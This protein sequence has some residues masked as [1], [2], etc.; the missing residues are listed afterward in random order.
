MSLLCR[1]L[2]ALCVVSLVYFFYLS[3]Y[4]CLAVAGFAFV[5]CGGFCANHFFLSLVCFFCANFSLLLMSVFI[6]FSAVECCLLRFV[7]FCFKSV[8]FVLFI[9]FCVSWRFVL[10]NMSFFAVDYAF[11]VFFWRFF[12]RFESCLSF[13]RIACCGFSCL[14]AFFSFSSLS[15]TKLTGGLARAGA[16]RRRWKSGLWAFGVFLAVEFC[17]RRTMVFFFCRVAAFLMERKRNCAGTVWRCLWGCALFACFF[18][19]CAPAFYFGFGNFCLELT[20][21]GYFFMMFL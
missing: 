18:V 8:L 20:K 16:A 14:D 10:L 9:E 13:F 17:G 2:R 1:C 19:W 6:F 15:K 12:V 5:V 4:C 3:F 7:F 21:G 11:F